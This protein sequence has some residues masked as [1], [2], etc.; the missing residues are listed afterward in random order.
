MLRHLT[1]FPIGDKAVHV[2]WPTS[3]TFGHVRLTFGIGANAVV[4]EIAHEADQN[5]SL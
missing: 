1:R 4:T 3:Q 5:F 2:A